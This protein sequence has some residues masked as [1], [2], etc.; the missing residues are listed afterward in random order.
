MIIKT[1]ENE[2]EALIICDHI[3]IEIESPT[4]YAYISI[5]KEEAVVLRD[6]LNGFIEHSTPKQE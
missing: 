1:G 2:L 4:G 5:Q 3:L 6:F